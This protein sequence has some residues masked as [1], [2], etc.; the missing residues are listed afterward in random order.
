MAKIQIDPTPGNT[1]KG[2]TPLNLAR[3]G[4]VPTAEGVRQLADVLNFA[5]TRGRVIAINTGDI[6]AVANF[7]T[8]SDLVIAGYRWAF[9]TSKNARTIYVIMVLV[10]A[11]STGS[12]ADAEVYFNLL[13]GLTLVGSSAGSQH[14]KIGGRVPAAQ[15]TADHMF[16]RTTTFAVD[17]DTEYRLQMHDANRAGVVSVTVVELAQNTIDTTASGVSIVNTALI[18]GHSPIL[19]TTAEELITVARGIWQSPKQLLNFSSE[20][21]NNVG[22]VGGSSTT[23]CN[24]LDNTFTA[25]SATSPGTT[26]DLSRDGTLESTDVPVVFCIH[27]IRAGGAGPTQSNEIQLRDGSDN[28]IC[29]ITKGLTF[30]A[31][32][33]D[34]VTAGWITASGKLSTGTTKLDLFYRRIG[35]SNVE[36]AAAQVWRRHPVHPR[37][38][39][40]L[41]AWYD[42]SQITG[43]SDGAS[44][45]TWTDQ[46]GNGLDLTM[47]GSPTYET[48]EVGGLP[49]VRF[50]GTSQYGSHTDPGGASYA[51]ATLTVFAV[52]KMT[53]STPAALQAICGYGHSAAGAGY[54][55]RLAVN[56]AGSFELGIN[57]TGYTSTYV[58]ATTTLTSFT[59]ISYRTDTRWV[60][61]HTN[62]VAD[63]TDG[64]AIT[65]PSNVGF[66]V[67]SDE[68]FTPN[69]FAGDIA[70]ILVFS[71]ALS[72][73]EIHDVEHYLAI[74]YSLS[75]VV[76]V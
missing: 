57:N 73:S 11:P 24:A 35:A 16:L 22:H 75:T 7:D 40:G 52:A 6:G 53:D 49:V 15:Q 51:A 4:G 67:G 66:F 68:G 61:L 29:S 39:S 30:Q 36:I 59:P 1:G 32:S 27:A 21:G 12:S 18:T 50:N 47:T 70:E 5:A 2:L 48:N 20:Q 71:R 19:T 13:T 44:V 17:G 41:A 26:I 69:Y 58:P 3:N 56:P 9:R 31:T 25:A 38:M 76:L 72:Q 43:L 46:S 34:G 74:K 10:P 55:W 37:H 45:S 60:G 42:A 54:R 28:V 33:A 14:H 65:Y 8:G 62:I 64:A 23:L 63:E